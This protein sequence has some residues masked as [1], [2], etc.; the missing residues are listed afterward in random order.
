MSMQKNPV[1]RRT[2]SEVK[3]PARQM[4][5]ESGDHRGQVVTCLRGIVWLT[6]ESMPGD[7]VLLPGQEF[8]VARRGLLLVQ[9]LRDAVVR[10]ADPAFPNS[11]AAKA[12]LN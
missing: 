12:S 7:Y 1:L 2:V 9:G 5:R 4:W 10:I 3:L 6:H 8:V 11:A